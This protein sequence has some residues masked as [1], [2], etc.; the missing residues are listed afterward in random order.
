MFDACLRVLTHTQQLVPR[1]ASFTLWLSKDSVKQRIRRCFEILQMKSSNQILGLY[2][3]PH[4]MPVVA[5]AGLSL[6]RRDARSCG[7]MEAFD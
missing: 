5:R 7:A 6:T 3:S 2:P 1:A 4:L